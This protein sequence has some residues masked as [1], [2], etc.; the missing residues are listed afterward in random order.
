MAIRRGTSGKDK[1]S[2]T[3][4]A[5]SLFGL[6]GNDNLLGLAG[7][8]TL[9][10]GTGNDVV[11][12]GAGNDVLIG[13][14]GDDRLVGGVGQDILNGGSGKDTML[15]G[16]GNDIY[17]VDS[18]GDVIDEQANLDTGDLVKSSATINLTKL[19]DSQ[20]EKATLIGAA[21]IDIK[22]SSVAEQLTGNNG[23]NLLNGNGGEDIIDG[24]DGKDTLVGGAGNDELTGGLGA[25]VMRGD[26]G[27]DELNG[28]D[29]PDVIMGGP[30][31]DILSGGLGNDTYIYEQGDLG[32]FGDVIIDFDSANG[33]F[34]VDVSDLIT[35]TPGVATGD[36]ISDFVRGSADSLTMIPFFS[37][38]LDGG[39][40]SPGGATLFQL[41][42]FSNTVKFTADGLTENISV[43]VIIIPD[44]L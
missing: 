29:G 42:G 21:D 33:G 10:G 38:D 22:G 30:G 2:G 27:N 18:A 15:G 37:I 7:D 23:D 17:F 13:S 11:N 26:M 32:G 31:S 40:G 36:Q 25:D 6:A 16:S 24:K 9:N 19:G 43:Q 1:L 44:P 12:G 4:A 8:D 3:A 35:I 20:I 28:G 41:A 39:L 14:G 34:I 5:D